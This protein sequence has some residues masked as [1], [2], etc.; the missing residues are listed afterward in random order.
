MSLG[1]SILRLL[2]E[3]PLQPGALADLLEVAR[4]QVEDAVSLLRS[5]GVEI[6]LHP[7]RGYILEALPE[8][9]LAEDLLSRPGT[10]WLGEVWTLES[11]GSTNT[12]ALEQGQL[13]LPGPLAIFAEHQTAGRGRFARKWESAAGEGL[14]LS[15]LLRPRAEQRFWPRLTALAALA[16]AR[17]CAA[18]LPED[19]V[20]IKWPNDVVA[21]GKKIAGI[22]AETGSDPGRGP[23]VVLG[24]GLNVNQT[25]FPPP[26]DDT[27]TS[28]RLLTG[29]TLERAAVAASLLGQLGELLPLME[30]HFSAPLAEVVQRS[31]VLGRRLSLHTGAAS[32][33]G[34]AEALDPEGLLQL[35]LDDGTL[36]SFSA[37]EVS[38]KPW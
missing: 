30:D 4:H 32:V 15:L 22:L 26:L 14:C 17:C 35:R 19:N 9:L 5:A 3:Q 6:P 38:V 37:G 24:I 31:S 11:A 16:V 2:R 8:K 10:A 36:Q 13:G 33:E 20:R 28:L 27:A 23:F 34:V 1:A 18:F 21:A 25:A 12:V 7:L 29:H